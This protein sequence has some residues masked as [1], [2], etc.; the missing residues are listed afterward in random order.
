MLTFAQV[1]QDDDLAAARDA[2]LLDTIDALDANP[3]T[4]EEV[5]RAR[6]T[7]SSATPDVALND[8][9]PRRHRAERVGRS[10]RLALALLITATS[11]TT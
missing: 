10:R 5:D 11:S 1:D 7:R 3:P 8:S 9:E 4:Q 2:T 6:S